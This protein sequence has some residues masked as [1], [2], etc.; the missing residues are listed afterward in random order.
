MINST[1]FL[2]PRVTVPLRELPIYLATRFVKTMSGT[3][4]CNVGTTNATGCFSQSYSNKCYNGCDGSGAGSFSMD[5]SHRHQVTLSGNT[6]YDG[7]S[8]N[9]E[10]RPFNFTIKVWVRTA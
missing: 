4:K 6:G 8:N 2:L 1:P 10:S 7:D 5:L 3:F 9:T